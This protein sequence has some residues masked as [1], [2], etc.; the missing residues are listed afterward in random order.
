MASKPNPF[1]ILD[2]MLQEVVQS[3]KPQ[4]PVQSSPGMVNLENQGYNNIWFSRAGRYDQAHKGTFGNQ[5]MVD[6]VAALNNEHFGFKPQ[7]SAGYADIGHSNGKGGEHVGGGVFDIGLSGRN[8]Q[9]AQQLKNWLSNQGVDYLE[10]SPGTNNWHLH[11]RGQGGGKNLPRPN[12]PRQIEP[13]SK[14]LP[15]KFLH[16]PLKSHRLPNSNPST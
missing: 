13:H 7:V 3:G 6:L 16:L 12:L 5:G 4:A 1:D 11:V 2:N 10:E 8:K 15:L 14:Q 9:E